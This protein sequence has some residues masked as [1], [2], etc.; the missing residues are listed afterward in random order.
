MWIKA[1]QYNYDS[2]MHHCDLAIIDMFI[3]SGA[4]KH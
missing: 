4:E 3:I 1:T 2:G